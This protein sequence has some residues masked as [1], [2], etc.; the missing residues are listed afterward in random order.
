MGNIETRSTFKDI[1]K[2]TH[3]G[4]AN[5][6]IR[7]SQEISKVFLGFKTGF[8][9]VTRLLDSY[10]HQARINFWVRFFSEHQRLA[11]QETTSIQAEKTGFS[12]LAAVTNMAL[13]YDK[14][15]ASLEQDLNNEFLVK[16]V[17]ENVV[18][19]NAQ[20]ADVAMAVPY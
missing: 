14:N 3:N 9:E 1:R 5:F 15:G 2:S 10:S 8:G 19:D 12:E 18:F 11:L 13:G 7:L 6:R 4:S 20:R 17:R 16:Q